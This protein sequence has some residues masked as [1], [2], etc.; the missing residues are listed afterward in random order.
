MKKIIILFIILIITILSFGDEWIRAFKKEYWSQNHLY[1]LTVFPTEFPNKAK[2]DT[3][4][5]R[6]VLW[7][8]IGDKIQ[9]VWEKELVNPIAPYN[10]FV[11][12]DGK[13]T[14]TFDDWYSLGI[15]E[16]VMAIYDSIGVFQKKYKLIDLAPIPINQLKQS[17]TSI[18]WF[19]GVETYS[20]FPNIVEILLV[21]NQDKFY[22]IKYNLDKLDFEE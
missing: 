4:N 8:Y 17:V 14:I 22:R 10:A 18:W 16:N 20:K 15:G 1:Q 5:C 3:I 12:N 21:D 6:A 11:T 2:D 19:Q 7:K 13:F 9:P